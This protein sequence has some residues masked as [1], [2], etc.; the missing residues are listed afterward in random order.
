MRYGSRT[1]QDSG[2]CER[3]LVSRMAIPTTKSS[4]VSVNA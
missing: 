2:R 4:Y 3:G 1:F